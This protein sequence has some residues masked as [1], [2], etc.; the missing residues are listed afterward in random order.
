MLIAILIVVNIPVAILFGWMIFGSWGGFTEC[1][2]YAIR[3][4]ILSWISGE[5]LDDMW[6]ELRLFIWL[7][8]CAGAGYGQWWVITNV[9]MSSPAS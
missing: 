8:L 4:D 6:A 7:A 5:A 9:V 1:L 2:G 3:P